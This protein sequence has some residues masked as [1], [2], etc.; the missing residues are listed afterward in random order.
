MGKVVC[1]LRG[2]SEKDWILQPIIS[3]LGVGDSKRLAMATRRAS[4]WM[5][6]LRV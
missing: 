1:Y 3:S 6:Q 2:S 5:A 4:A